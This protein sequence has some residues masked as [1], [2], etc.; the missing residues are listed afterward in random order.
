[1]YVVIRTRC[2]IKRWFLLLTVV[3]L[4]SRWFSGGFLRQWFGLTRFV[5]ARSPRTVCH[6]TRENY[7]TCNR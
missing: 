2:S 6:H 5:F 4:I 3:G 1:M 7:A